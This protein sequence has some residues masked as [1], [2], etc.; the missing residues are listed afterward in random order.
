MKT[1]TK[2]FKKLQKENSKLRKSF[3]ILLKDLKPTEQ[4]KVFN[5][6]NEIVNNEIKQ[7]ALCNF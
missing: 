6:L 4:E 2:E 3:A 1:Q 7:E 5:F